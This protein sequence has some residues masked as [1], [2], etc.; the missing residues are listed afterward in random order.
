MPKVSVIMPA[1]NAEQYI[2]EAID[3]I[4]KQTF[5]DFE[6]II[7]ND[8]SRDSTEEIIRSFWDPR[9][10]YLK[11]EKNMG[12]A[13]TLNRGLAAACGE[14]V[15][16]MD[17][18]DIAL[19]ERFALQVEYLDSH[20]NTAV[21]ASAVELF[22]AQSGVRIFSETSEALKVDL[23]F[24]NCF[25]HPSVMMRTEMIRDLGGYDRSFEGVEDYHLWVRAVQKYEIASIPQVLLRYRI[26]PHQVTQTQSV[27]KR[28]HNI[29]RLKELQLAPLGM[30]DPAGFRAFC[31][32]QGN[33]VEYQRFTKVLKRRNKEKVV[34]APGYLEDALWNT[35]FQA[36]DH[37]SFLQACKTTDRPIKYA[38]SRIVRRAVLELKKP[39]ERREKQKQLKYKD[40]TILSNNCWGGSVYQK[41]GL[42]YL[43]PTAGLFFLGDD[44]VKFCADWQR[45]TRM[46]LEFI[47]WESARYYPAIKDDKPYPVAKLG[48]IEVYFMHYPTAQEAEEKWLRRVERINPERL[49]FKLS[50]RECCTKEDLQRFMELPHPNKI[51]FSYDQVEGAIQI[52]ELE[53]LKGDEKYYIQANFDELVYLNSLD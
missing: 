49:I 14:Y 15:A 20:P 23:L 7:L 39:M 8:C 32:P 40:F 29:R 12:V 11:N 48:D 3:S 46:K 37:L 44:F 22:G 6:L 27:D 41:Y 10:V 50:Q 42:P 1:Y 13:G 17:A 45:Y 43:T 31:C 35:S 47:P 18:D 4:L 28:D 33:I 5:T 34:F 9:I 30:E 38:V 36:L 24:A 25:A 21:V 16:R 19:P 2:E 26:H 51:C 53:T 52:P